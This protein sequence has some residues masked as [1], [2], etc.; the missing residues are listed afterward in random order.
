M[1]RS[2][3]LDRAIPWTELLI[4]DRRVDGFVLSR[5]QQ[6]SAIFVVVSSMSLLTAWISPWLFAS[7]GLGVVGFAVSNLHIWRFLHR[8]RGLMFTLQGVALLYLHVA[9]S[10][11]GLALGLARALWTNLTHFC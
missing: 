7:F 6:W 8:K 9:T 3:L 2:D 1:V 5:A 10:V 11:L 4:A